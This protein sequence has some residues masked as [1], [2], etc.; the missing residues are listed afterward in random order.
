MNLIVYALLPGLMLLMYG[1]LLST[2]VHI[3]YQPDRRMET[4]AAHAG[5]VTL[6]LYALWMTL[7]TISQNQLPILN[8]GQVAAF[9]GFLIWA[10]QSLV[11]LKVRQRMLALLPIAA[12]TLLLLIGIVAGARPDEIPPKV[13]GPWVAFHITLSLAGV[14]MLM[15]AGVYGA[16]YLILHRQMK[17]RSF[18][19]LFS[20]LPSMEEIHRLRVVAV[21]VG[22]LLITV[23]LF[24]SSVWMLLYKSLDDI[25]HSHLAGMIGLWLA[26]SGLALADRK[27]WASARRMAALTL[28]LMGIVLLLI[29]AT[30]IGIFAGAG[31]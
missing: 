7:I 26:V 2:Y 18:G 16:G 29:V 24:S 12:V 20:R 15:G 9:L 31:A 19:S 3:A 8:A 6:G 27:R 5:H 21:G 1:G 23:S 13:H 10:D 25:L 30:V 14:A 11:Q 22:W 17:T 28:A 4:A